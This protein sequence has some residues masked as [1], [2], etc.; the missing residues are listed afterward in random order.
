[1]RSPASRAFR[2][3]ARARWALPVTALLLA[4]A[5]VA[6][7]VAGLV[8]VN[9]SRTTVLAGHEA[10]VRPT[11]DGW[12]EIGLGPLLPGFR[13]PTTSRIGADIT[14]GKTTLTS[15]DDL[16]ARY[17]LLAGR[18]QGQIV[19]VES[20]V[21]EMAVAAVL[22][23]ALAGLAAPGLWWLVGARRRREIARS[24]RDL[25]LVAGV[26]V[27][28][29]AAGV[30]VWV[31]PWDRA[32]GYGSTSWQPIAAALPDVAIPPE[33]RPLQVDAGLLTRGTERLVESAID[34]YRKSSGFYSEAAE[35]ATGL[36]DEVRA[37]GEGESVAVLV[38][39]RH[40]N[41]LMD[42][43][44]RA[45]ADAA[46]ATWLLDAGDDT[47]TGSSWEAFSL[48]SL[49]EAFSD[50]EHRFF[51]AGNHD[52]GSFLTDQA[53]ELGF[54]VLSGEVVEGPD[55]VRLL[56][57][58]DPR[59]SALGSWRDETGLSFEEVQARLAD[60]ACAADDAG[61]RVSTV[62]VHDA[63]LAGPALER[64]CVDLVLAGHLHVVVGPDPVTAE[65]GGVGYSYTSGTTGGAAYAI[66]IGTKPRRDATVSLVT[67]RDGR[68]VGVQWVSLSSIG[69]FTV[70]PFMPIQLERLSPAD[71]G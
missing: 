48:E 31:R 30:G 14:L 17:A 33:A 52:H 21:T 35:A 41:I 59:S 58:G 36:V 56:G 70:G 24:R 7:P 29:L 51:V 65:D 55:D 63:D 50:Y 71:D 66:A 38:S 40:D 18:P 27:A 23:G 13:Y 19:K 54:T 69:R 64:G 20:V 11:F 44:A 34:S 57:V 4:W 3:P 47:S 42:P 37:P 53:D 60:A 26:A 16:I 1:M 45:V 39:D 61:E 15:Y 67:Y 46:G 10:V 32:D 8:F 2:R 68:P 43:V 28:L 9:S 25:A 6:I 62:L 5:L 49:T 22:T 12:A